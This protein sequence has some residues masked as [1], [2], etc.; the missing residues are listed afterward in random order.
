MMMMMMGERGI[1]LRG[2]VV[3]MRMWLGWGGRC[4]LMRV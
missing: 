1:E 2:I 4:L 3:V